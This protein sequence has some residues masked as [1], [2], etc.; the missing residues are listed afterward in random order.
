M[1]HVCACVCECIHGGYLKTFRV[2]CVAVPVA[3]PTARDFICTGPRLSIKSLCTEAAPKLPP[4]AVPVLP[5]PAFSS[6]P[7]PAPSL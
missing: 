6:P 4:S 2:V 3:P 1:R 5:L 7:L